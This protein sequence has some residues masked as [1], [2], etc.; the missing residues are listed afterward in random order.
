MSELSRGA[1]RALHLVLATGFTAVTLAT[2]AACSVSKEPPKVTLG[3]DSANPHAVDSANPHADRLP[4]AARKAI[5]LANAEFRAGKYDD[6]LRAYREAAKASPDNAA[7]F[8][9]IYMVAQKQGNTPL[10]D[11]AL[12]VIQANSGLSDSALRDVHVS[13]KPARANKS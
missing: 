7:A 10:A 12:K 8:F 13:S 1:R 6:A 5:D 9:G 4:P 11:S 2:L 3:M